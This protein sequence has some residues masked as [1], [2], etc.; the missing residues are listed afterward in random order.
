MNTTL[1]PIPTS[2][3]TDWSSFHEVFAEA[4]GFPS[5]YGRNMNAWIDCMTYADDP[6]A[7]M[8]ARGVR[9]GELL[10]LRIDDAS[11]F[12]DRCPEQFKA[13]VECTA[14]V[15]YRRVEVAEKQ[16]LCLLMS[17]HFA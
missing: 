17:G 1:V 11:D 3:I 7:G 4:L 5:F 16:V 2:Q 14:F 6:V 13:L 9:P 15:N 8:L 12:A 10:T